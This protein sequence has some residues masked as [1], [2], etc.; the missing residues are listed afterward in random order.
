MRKSSSLSA[1]RRGRPAGWFGKQKCSLSRGPCSATKTAALSS[2]GSRIALRPIVPAMDVMPWR[3]SCGSPT[4]VG[5]TNR[6][7][8]YFDMLAGARRSSCTP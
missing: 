1:S 7:V 2:T 5:Q 6:P 4:M 8:R 3:S